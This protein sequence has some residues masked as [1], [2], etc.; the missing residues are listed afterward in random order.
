MTFVNLGTP[1]STV[2]YP[3]WRTSVIALV[4]RALCEAWLRVKQHHPQLLPSA[5]ADED[6]ITDQLKTELVALRKTNTPNGFNDDLFGIPTRDSKLQNVSGSSIDPMPDLTIY[7]AKS[8]PA[9]TDDQHDALF[10]ECK[11]IDKA[12]PLSLYD[13]HGIQR[14]INGWY[15]GYM[16]HAGMIAYVLET[17]NKCPISSL[18]KYMDKTKIGSKDKNSV[19]LRCSSPPSKALPSPN[20]SIASDI[21]QSIHA[22]PSRPDISL[23]HLWFFT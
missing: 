10:F 8:R 20:T 14:F 15:A 1:P 5:N 3:S 19:H 16:P 12:R 4:E 22:R 18:A 17:S 2:I 13:K 9:V 6:L 7:L 23:R 21:A 11:V